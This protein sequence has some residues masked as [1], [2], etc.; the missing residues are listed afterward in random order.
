MSKPLLTMSGL[1]A[2]HELDGHT[3]TD[4]A[5][6]ESS[7]LCCS[8]IFDRKKERRNS[9][10]SEI[11]FAFTSYKKFDKLLTCFHQK[12]LEIQQGLLGRV[13]VDK[14]RRNA[15]LAAAS[16]SSDLVNIV[17]NLFWHREDNDVLNVIEI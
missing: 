8:W 11:F 9:S 17:F 1:P 14:C 7:S 2:F 12:V 10:R 6:F 3:S 15:G 16:C 13:H 5:T 4:G